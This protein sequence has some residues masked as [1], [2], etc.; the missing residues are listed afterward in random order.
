MH[1]VL[2]LL[3]LLIAGLGGGQRVVAVAHGEQQGRHAG[4]AV[5]LL[6]G[7]VGGKALQC[8]GHS[9]H[10]LVGQL[11]APNMAAVLHQVEVIQLLHGIGCRRQ[12]LDDGLIGIVYQQHHMGQ[13]DG[14]VAA[15]L[16]TGRDAIQHCPLGGTNQGAGAGVKS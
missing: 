10:L 15:Y 7:L 8:L 11:V 6:H 3:L 12:R 2:A 14:S 4:N 1:Q 16:G 9:V 13:L 5:L